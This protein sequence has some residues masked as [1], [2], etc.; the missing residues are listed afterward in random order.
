MLVCQLKG[1]PVRIAEMNTQE[2]EEARGSHGRAE[3]LTVA[4]RTLKVMKALSELDDALIPTRNTNHTAHVCAAAIAPT[5]SLAIVPYRPAPL[6]RVNLAAADNGKIPHSVPV[7]FGAA[8]RG[9][10]TMLRS[11]Q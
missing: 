9:L 5:L 3:A 6:N 11:L 10:G 8:L 7:F 4:K 2:F 1:G